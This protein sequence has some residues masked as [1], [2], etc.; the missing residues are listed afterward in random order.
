M[1][2]PWRSVALELAAAGLLLKQYTTL[3]KENRKDSPVG[4]FVD[5]TVGNTSED[6]STCT[7]KI[8]SLWIVVSHNYYY[9]SAVWKSCKCS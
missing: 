1:R 6:K 3:E 4:V 5:G 8:S 9:S 7:I 2:Q